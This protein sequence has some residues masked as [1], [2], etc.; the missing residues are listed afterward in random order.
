MK[1]DLK[2]RFEDRVVVG[3]RGEVEVVASSFIVTEL[4]S[5]K[6][7]CVV[8]RDT[9]PHF[10]ERS[11]ALMCD[12]VAVSTINWS[13]TPDRAQLEAAVRQVLTMVSSKGPLQ[14]VS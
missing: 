2:V 3:Q 12:D 5:G 7:H 1:K 11:S 13:D 8:V 10:H 6:S 14:G 9:N 4:P